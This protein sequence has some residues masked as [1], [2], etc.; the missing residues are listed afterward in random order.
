[1]TG[2]QV[3]VRR[4]A[5][6][7]LAIAAALLTFVG[8]LVGQLLAL[9]ADGLPFSN[10][11]DRDWQLLATTAIQA[12]LSTV[13][14]L[15]VG[16][17]VAWSLYHQPRFPGRGLLVALFSS[18]LVLPTL[19]VV[20]GLVTVLGRNGWFNGMLSFTLGMDGGGF[21]YGMA[22]IL[23]AH[24][25]LN[26]SF[27]VRALLNR[28]E[29]IPEEKQKLAR[30]LNLTVWQR[31]RFVEWPAIRT[32]VPGIGAIIFLL[33]F[34][35]FAIVLTL[36]G[37]PKN[38]TLEVAIYEAVKLDF[39]IPHALDLAFL[40]LLICAALVFA[41]AGY[42]TQARLV[43]KPLSGT[44]GWGERTAPR[45]VQKA[46]IALACLG[47]VLPLVAI[48]LDGFSADFS[49]LTAEPGFQRAFV[50]SLLVA[51]A[52]SAITVGFAVLMAA[53]KRNFTLPSRQNAGLFAKLLAGLISFSSALYLA[54]PSLVLALGMFVVARKLPG[55]LDS[56][57]LVAVLTA[58]VLLAL[59]FA[60]TV[61]FPAFEK[62]A[63]KYD[64]LAFSLGLTTLAIWRLCEWPLLRKDLV[65]VATIAFCF[66]FGDL[67]VIALFG[68]Q[69][70]ATLPWYLYQK[71]GSYR[72]DDAAGVALIM[73]AITL[74][75]FL[76]LPWIMERIGQ[77][78]GADHVAG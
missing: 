59:P 26:G 20:L 22:G 50:T 3:G 10:L 76:V 62:T 74:V 12:S 13:L 55:S 44:P 21:L 8:L 42:R 36:G 46:I 31:F 67:G 43:A 37:S 2:L 11:T 9:Q 75:V 61:L 65:Y 73:L 78:K 17:V 69:D 71:M 19:V 51:T 35:S 4:S 56:W 6:P 28:M 29:A 18:A 60:L 63:F 53:A 40:Q 66:S 38:N 52:S 30:S 45:M 72:T 23:I 7:G 34:T 57:A 58:N 70:V 54:F 32:T 27:A 5:V 64:R 49:R 47:F 77:T 41:A 15:I 48:S 24:T 39:D 14:S 16:V 25:Y 33:C 1:M 68:S